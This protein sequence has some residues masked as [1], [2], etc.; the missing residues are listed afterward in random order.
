MT[1]RGYSMNKHKKKMIGP[2]IITILILAYVVFYVYM[3]ITT[4]DYSLGTLLLSIPLI[5]LGIGMI[6]TLLTRIKEIK[7]GEED[8]LSDY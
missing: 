4:A 3:I 6:Y 7:E 5:A 2:I 8:D 1:E